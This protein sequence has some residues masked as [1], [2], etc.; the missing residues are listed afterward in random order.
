LA[1][2]ELGRDIT[3]ENTRIYDGSWAEWGKEDAL[4]KVLPNEMK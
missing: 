4:P 2:K 3:E 1:L